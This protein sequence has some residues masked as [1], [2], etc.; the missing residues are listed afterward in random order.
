MQEA[1]P[2]AAVAAAKTLHLCLTLCHPWDCSCL[3]CLLH[4]QAGSLPLAPP[5]K[6]RLSYLELNILFHNNSLET[7]WN[8]DKMVLWDKQYFSKPSFIEAQEVY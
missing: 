4:W 5:G 8:P 1:Y 6:P 3:F 2:A 7:H